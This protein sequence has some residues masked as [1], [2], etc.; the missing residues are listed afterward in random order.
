ME[1]KKICRAEQ[2]AERIFWEKLGNSDFNTCKK[3]FVNENCYTTLCPN[4]KLVLCRKIC[5]RW[6][7]KNQTFQAFLAMEQEQW[8]R[9]LSKR[10]YI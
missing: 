9:Q 8:K 5:A 3:V 4:Y 6:Y 1:R 10:N 2:I 7:K